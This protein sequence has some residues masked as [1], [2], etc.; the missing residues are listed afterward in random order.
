MKLDAIEQEILDILASHEG[1]TITAIEKRIKF[2]RH[3]LSKYL[4]LIE[5]NGLI[6]H[7][8][9]GKAK[10]WYINKAPLQT[11]LNAVSDSMTFTEHILS[12]IVSNLP[13]GLAVID[14]DYNILF[15]ND[16][17]KDMYGSVEGKFY[18]KIIGSHNPLVLQD[19][20]HLIDG[21]ID[22]AECIVQD[23]SGNHLKIRASTLPHPYNT[24]SY[25]LIIDD[26]TALLRAQSAL[27]EKTALLEAER[28]A[29]NA[30]AIVVETDLQGVITFVNDQFVTVSGYSREELIG[31]THRIIN[32]HYHPKT[33]FIELW[34]TIKS[35]KVWTGL[36]RNKRKDG[37]FYWVESTITPVLD[38]KGKPFKYLAVRFDVTKYHS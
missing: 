20:R 5:K 23:K 11:I 17:L 25:I 33:F 2:E 7:K 36:I 19:I 32:S 34:D 12:K 27:S 14:R 15:L 18:E 28:Q 21:K 6:H 35:G 31:Q 9:I 30:A 3:T 16:R 10:V 37:R 8:K 29:L 38:H 13:H 4:S 1:A 22:I 26:I 24:N